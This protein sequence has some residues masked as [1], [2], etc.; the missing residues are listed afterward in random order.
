VSPT[1]PG[2]N[3]DVLVVDD[4]S[5]VCDCIRLVLEADGLTVATAGDVASALQHQALPACRLLIC[6]LMLPDRSGIELVLAARAQRPGLPIVVIT[7]YATT[8]HNLQ[9][10]EAGADDFL[11][12]P[13][14]EEELLRVVHRALAKHLAGSKER[15]S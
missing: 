15:R 14:D 3:A 9:A 5:V 12:K 8:T 7:G 11:P 6:D 10:I 4:E 2:S 13:F 1:D